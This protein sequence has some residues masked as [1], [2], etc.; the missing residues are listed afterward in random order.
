MPFDSF[1]KVG[2]FDAEAFGFYDEF[3]N[4]IREKGGSFGFCGGGALGDDSPR[5]GTNFEEPCVD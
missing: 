2:E 3:L 1:L 4:R 5:A